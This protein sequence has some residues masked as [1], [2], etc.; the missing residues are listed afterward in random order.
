MNQQLRSNTPLQSEAGLIDTHCHL[1]MEAYGNDLESHIRSAAKQGVRG[2]ITIGIDLASSARAVEIARE[3]PGVWAS[4]GIHP[5]NAGQ[6]C[7]EVYDKLADLAGDPANKVVGL[8]EIGLDFAKNYT[9]RDIQLTTF[10]DQLTLALQLQLPII[11]HDREAHE[12]T[13]SILREH[14]PFP[15]SGVMHCFSGDMNLAREMLDLGLY[16]SI[17]G[18]VTFKN[19]RLLQRVAAEI[20]LERIILE[21]DGPFL[22][23][24][25]YRGKVNRPAYLPHTAGKIAEL[26]G[27]SLEDV[28]RQT[29]SNA[30]RLFHLS[31]EE[32]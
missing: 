32:A 14:A 12:E 15:H 28:T 11:I 27:I 5:H 17:P 4:V 30:E 9:P 21:T 18:I 25:P 22:A 7:R 29:T 6:G 20:P 24:V 19:A 3:F 1:D 26:R 16:I 8:G 23:P 10:A 2:I 31:R 13:I